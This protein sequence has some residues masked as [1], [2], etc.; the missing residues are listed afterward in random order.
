MP[1]KQELL[2][3]HKGFVALLKCCKELVAGFRSEFLNKQNLELV[4]YAH[5]LSKKY[6]M[7]QVDDLFMVKARDPEFKL[8]RHYAN[9]KGYDKNID[10]SR[11]LTLFVRTKSF[12]EQY[13][14]AIGAK[15]I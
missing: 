10:L 8:C 3:F 2:M 5:Q 4:K 15:A 12:P 13:R 7:F 9:G 11:C 14:S 6:G 1:S